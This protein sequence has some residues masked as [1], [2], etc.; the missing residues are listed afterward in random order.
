M[1]A[2]G[3]QATGVS[4]NDNAPSIFSQAASWNELQESMGANC[5]G[6]TTFYKRGHDPAFWYTPLA[7]ACKLNDMPVAAT[8]VGTISLP[9]TLPAY[10]FITPNL[11]H[12]NHWQTGCPSRTRRLGTSCAMD[13]WLHGMVGE[14]AQSTDYQPGRTLILIAFDESL[15]LDGHPRSRDRRRRRHRAG[16]GRHQLR[17]VRAPA[18]DRAGAR[19]HDVPRK[20]RRRERHARRN[21]LLDSADLLDAVD[22]PSQGP[23]LEQGDGRLDV[24]VAHDLGVSSHL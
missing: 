9:A 15:E 18:G 17:P 11:C 14:I 13:T 2:T 10:T 8:D 21:A 12:N 5:G 4:V 1:A 24:V 23:P 16:H 20:R 7:A 19:H 6:T 22:R 3:G